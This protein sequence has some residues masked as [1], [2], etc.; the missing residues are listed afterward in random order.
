MSEIFSLPVE[1]NYEDTDAGGVV[2]HAN[3]LA[4]MERARS[5]CL[6]QSGLPVSKLKNEHNLLF[7]VSETHLKFVKPAFLDDI[8]NVTVQVERLKGASVACVQRISRG[9]DLLVDASIRI[10]TIAADSFSPQRMPQVLREIFGRYQL[11]Y[12]GPEEITRK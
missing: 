3:Y 8:V 12:A 11:E 5:A 9:G 1:I 4:F 6:R 10:A 7:V 2:Y